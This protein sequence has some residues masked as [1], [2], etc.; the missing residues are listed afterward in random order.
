MM[1]YELQRSGV[2]LKTRLV[3][4]LPAV[5]ADRIQLQQVILNLMLNG[6]EAT[7]DIEGR[8]RHISIASRLDGRQAVHIEVRDSGVGLDPGSRK[9]LFE[10]FHT[11]KPN[12]L[13]M[14]LAISRSIVEAYGGRLWAT[15]NEPR[16]AVFQFTLP[17]V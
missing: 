10:A 2:A 17:L 4:D 13:G 5:P 8:A 14:G 3:E 11:T 6:I 12:G 1:R 7:R 16:G 15:D 9:R